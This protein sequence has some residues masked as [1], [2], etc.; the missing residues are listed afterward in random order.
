MVL[1]GGLKGVYFGIGLTTWVQLCRLIRAEVLK[2]KQLTYVRA[3]RTL[4]LGHTRVLFRHIL[5]NIM[6]LVIINFSMRFP[7]AISTATGSRPPCRPPC[8]PP[9]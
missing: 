2:H 1:E 4:G 6:H 7:A 3:A 8:R 9:A 5:P